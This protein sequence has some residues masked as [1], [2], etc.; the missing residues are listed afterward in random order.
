MGRALTG[1]V[2]QRKTKSGFTYYAR[3]KAY[4]RQWRIHLGGTSNGMTPTKAEEAMQA[5]VADVRR[6]RW[7]PQRDGANGSGN[8]R[9]LE[10]TATMHEL[11]SEWLGG[12]SDLGDA[13]KADYTWQLTNHILPFF[14]D[15]FP[16]EI[17]PQELDRFRKDR[18]DAGLGAV[19][20]N[21]CI[22]LI[23]QILDVAE[24]YGLVNGNPA[25]NRRRYAKK[26]V[27]RAVWLDRAEQIQAILDAALALDAAP[28]R[29]TQGREA[30]VATLVLAGLRIS[31]ACRLEWRAIDFHNDLIR[32]EQRAKST[33]GFRE[34]DLFPALKRRLVAERARR[35]PSSMNELVFTTSTGQPRDR[36]NAAKRVINP[37]KTLADELLIA[38]EHAPLPVGVTAHKLRHTFASLLIAMGYD[39][40]TVQEQ[41][42]HAD[43]R[44]TL[45]VYTHQMRRGPDDRAALAALLE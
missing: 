33:A 6:G 9:P 30:L 23:A 28:D 32:V 8:A 39:P 18:L 22:R 7:L 25:R 13:G 35:R 3:F 26:P 41:L 44:F 1:S 37:T 29:R 2:E 20:V 19:S 4:G 11:A 34:I 27:Q 17:T 12:R 42:G 40:A 31:E 14:K 5:I 21:K 24:D 15:H 43:A 10:A 45:N 38:R 36:N 16:F